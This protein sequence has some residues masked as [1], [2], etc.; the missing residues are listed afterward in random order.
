MTPFKA[1]YVREPP[2]LVCY[3]GQST[4]VQELDDQLVEC[5]RVLQELKKR[6]TL[7]FGLATGFIYVFSLIVNIQSSSVFPTNFPHVTMDHSVLK[8]ALDPSLIACSY[9]RVLECITSST[10]LFSKDML[11]LIHQHRVPYLLS[12]LMEFSDLNLCVCCVIETMNMGVSSY[13]RLSYN[14]KIYQM[15]MLHGRKLISYVEAFQL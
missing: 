11:A 5:D 4:P 2:A 1:M 8:P 9:R 14:G 6:E 7:L 12:A 15:R 10:F 3:E 13:R